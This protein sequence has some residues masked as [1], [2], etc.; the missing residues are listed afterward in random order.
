VQEVSAEASDKVDL[1]LL[2]NAVNKIQTSCEDTPEV[3]LGKL[4][5]IESLLQKIGAT[6]DTPQIYPLRLKLVKTLLEKAAGCFTTKKFDL[7]ASHDNTLFE[8]VYALTMLNPSLVGSKLFFS[9]ELTAYCKYPD[10]MNH[11]ELLA[12]YNTVQ[13]L[14]KQFGEFYYRMIRPIE[15]IQGYLPEIESNLQEFQG[16]LQSLEMLVK[17]KHAIDSDWFNSLE[18][19]R[20]FTPF[21][22]AITQIPSYLRNKFPLFVQAIKMHDDFY[23]LRG[24]QNQL[25][26]EVLK[27]SKAQP[28]TIPSEAA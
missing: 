20:S 28:A 19:S 14:K 25:L 6:K 13:G 18:V 21:T 17:G 22:E 26:S 24:K 2:E 3:S 15:T 23:K 5:E 12:E 8:R 27:R 9:L 1:V 4:Q 10:N 16:L 11:P 7:Y